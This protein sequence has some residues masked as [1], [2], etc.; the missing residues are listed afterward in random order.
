MINSTIETFGAPNDKEITSH[1]KKI[2]EGKTNLQKLNAA[3][4]AML[5]A[6]VDYCVARDAGENKAR[7]E[8]QIK[9]AESKL[10]QL[11]NQKTHMGYDKRKQFTDNIM[12]LLL[13]K[14]QALTVGVLFDFSFHFYFAS[15]FVGNWNLCPFYNE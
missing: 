3:Y 4:L 7:L 13:T 1:E 2:E 10:E 11:N 14:L 15:F 8:Q 9:E 6:P 5:S 12:N